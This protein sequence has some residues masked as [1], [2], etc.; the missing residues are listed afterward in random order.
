[1][2]TGKYASYTYGVSSKELFCDGKQIPTDF[3]SEIVIIE[4]DKKLA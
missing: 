1:M 2:K 4:V 3:N